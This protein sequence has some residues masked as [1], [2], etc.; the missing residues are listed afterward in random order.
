MVNYSACPVCKSAAILPNMMVKD[1]TVT[2]EEF[3]VWYCSDCTMKFTQD[4]PDQ[5]SIT[6]YYQVSNYISHSDTQEGLI[7]KMYHLVRNITLK[8]KQQLIVNQTKK[9]TG[10]ILDIGCG[11]GAFL[12]TMQQN[13]WSITGLEPDEI[14]V[15]NAK[16][17]YGIAAQ[18]PDRLFDFPEKKFDAITM[19]HVLEHVHQLHD[20]IE[21]LKKI[22]KDDGTIFIA[23]P[24]YTAADAEH[25]KSFWA[26][27]DVP[28]HLYHF[29]PKSM[30]KLLA[31]HG[32]KIK[33]FQPMWYDSFYVSMLSEKYKNGAGKLLSAFWFGLTSNIKA[34]HDYS[35]CSSV[36]YVIGK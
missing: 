5:N 20:Y 18:S 25:Y 12:N 15:A 27:Y 23:V 2:M 16:A 9:K 8:K 31:K 22:L 11:T 1:Y 32:L 30:E 21:C 36:I 17:K 29:S 14:A 34:M 10:E 13:G 19:W 35:K 33:S 4:V 24:N 3:S 28:R 7:N 6:K 26:A